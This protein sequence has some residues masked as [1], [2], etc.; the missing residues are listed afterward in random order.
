MNPIK[1]I[2]RAGKHYSRNFLRL[3]ITFRSKI[4][5]KY[6]ISAAARYDYNKVVNGWSKIIGLSD[7][8]P[9]LNSCRLAFINNGYGLQVGFYSYCKG[10]RK[11]SPVTGI[12]PGVVYSIK[13]ERKRKEYIISHT[14]AEGVTSTSFLPMPDRYLPW[15]FIL[16]PY[17]GGRFTLDKDLTILIYK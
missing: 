15:Q 2:I 14:T 13:I 7:W 10:V 5:F 4:E 12:V 6:S 9:H 16:H 11:M 3:R 1:F 8:W 17:V